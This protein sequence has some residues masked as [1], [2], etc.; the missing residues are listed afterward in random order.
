MARILKLHKLPLSVV[1]KFGVDGLTNMQELW[2]K[3]V[4]RGSDWVHH[5]DDCH[6][7]SHEG[8]S[9]MDSD[10]AMRHVGNGAFI[11]PGT[12][13]CACLQQRASGSYKEFE[14]QLFAGGAS[15]ERLRGS[16]GKEKSS[17]SRALFTGL[18][19]GSHGSPWISGHIA[20][21]SAVATRQ[22]R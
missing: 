1:E 10:N 15:L 11:A 9:H 2:E 19:G 20:K 12:A 22:C 18:Q 8:K 3:A 17:E 14:P 7:G 21:E 16:C 4:I 13:S 5:V 6:N